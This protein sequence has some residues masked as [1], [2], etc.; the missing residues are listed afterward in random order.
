MQSNTYKRVSAIDTD[1]GEVLGNALI[2]DNG[3]EQLVMRV[4]KENQ[5]KAVKKKTKNKGAIVEHIQEN[6]G[7]FVHLIY[8]YR[9]PIMDTL[10][11]KCKGNKADIHIIRYIQLA[12]YST[13]GGKLFDDNRNEIK[14]SSLSKIWD[15]TSRNSV[16][17]TYKLLIECGY[18]YE[19]EEGYIMISED[20]IVK[21]A[22]EDFKKLKK[23]DADLTY[24]RLFTKNIQTMYEG[25]EPKARKQLATLF[26]ILPYINFTHNV[27]CMNPTEVDHK[28]LD[29]LSWSD[30]ARICG[31]DEN[32]NLTRFKNE[33]YKLKVN[34][35]YVIGQF[36]SS[37]SKNNYKICVN[38]K[39]YYS[40]NDIEDLK[41]L[42]RLFEM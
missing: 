5:A 16:N 24:T 7:S 21:G 1:T 40:G 20:L 36:T 2:K 30:V 35:R 17:E 14:R 3:S 4:V 41:A 12:T 19:T 10:Q 39:V 28:K 27:L 18:I 29:M 37:D 13:F 25:T 11:A 32:K 23:D 42:Y 31:V 6:E 38:P 33:L 22:I 15:T 34:D 26:K 9:K 8:K